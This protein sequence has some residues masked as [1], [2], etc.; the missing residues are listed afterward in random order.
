MVVA[1]P[2]LVIRLRK[3]TKMSRRSFARAVPRH[4]AESLIRDELQASSPP[5]T[6]KK[7]TRKSRVDRLLEAVVEQEDSDPLPPL[8]LDRYDRTRFTG[9]EKGSHIVAVVR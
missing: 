2:R 9:I 4:A 5:P 3:V 8:G 6:R 7:G 1:C